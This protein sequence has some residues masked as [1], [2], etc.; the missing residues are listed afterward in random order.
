M[1]IFQ[2]FIDYAEIFIFI[3]IGLL[4]ECLVSVMHQFKGRQL[5]AEGLRGGFRNTEILGH[6]RAGESPLVTN[7]II[8]LGRRGDFP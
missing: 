2:K 6:Q 5:D 8:T 3:F 1:G 7:K 4:R